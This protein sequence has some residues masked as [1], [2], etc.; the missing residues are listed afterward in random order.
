M[1]IDQLTAS[2]RKHGTSTT[3]HDALFHFDTQI[4]QLFI[5]LKQA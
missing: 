1:V 5:D 2:T 3:T 4:I